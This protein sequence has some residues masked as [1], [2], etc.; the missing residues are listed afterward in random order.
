M[1][2]AP[3]GTRWLSGKRHPYGLR[4]QLLEDYKNRVHETDSKGKVLVA[5]SMSQKVC[6]FSLH[7][8]T[9]LPL[10]HSQ[11]FAALW[12]AKL[13]ISHDACISAIKRWKAKGL[14]HFENNKRCALSVGS[15]RKTP[16]AVVEKRILDWV[17]ERRKKGLR[18]T[19]YELQV[20]ARKQLQQEPGPGFTVCANWVGRFLRRHGLTLREPTKACSKLPEEMT[21]K[22]I[23]YHRFCIRLQRRLG[24]PDGKRL[25]IIN[26]DQIPF[27]RDPHTDRDLTFPKSCVLTPI[28]Q[29]H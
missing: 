11:A 7:F 18:V 14:E 1:P 9:Y 22:I 15:G 29:N 8:P 17:Q 21:Q 6:H 19:T 25:T 3:A 16:H 20:E 4:C 10:L 27:W 26:A 23:C 28:G 2:R 12:S 24:G 5:K 13:G